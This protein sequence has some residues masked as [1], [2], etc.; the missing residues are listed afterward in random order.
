MGITD[1][2]DDTARAD[3]QSGTKRMLGITA[4][5]FVAVPADIPLVNEFPVH[6]L[7]LI[8]V[9]T[10]ATVLIWVFVGYPLLMLRFA[11]VHKGAKK[12]YAFQPFFSILVPT[13]NE[14]AVI[15]KRIQNLQALRYPK[16]KYEIL[17]IDSGSS[18]ATT[19]I[20]ERLCAEDGAP[21]TKLVC[22]DERMGKASAINCGSA[23]AAGDIILV[24]DANAFFDADVLAELGPHFERAEIGGV[25]G[26]YVVS[27]PENPLPRTE[28]FYW[29][30]ETLLRTGESALDSACLFQ[31]EINAWRKSIVDADT[32]M[33][34][35]DLDMSIAIRKKG[36]KVAFEP[37]AICYEPSPTSFSEQRTQKQRRCLGTIQNIFKH[38]RYLFVPTD[39][40]RLIIFPSHKGLLMATPFM[41]FGILVC[42]TLIWNPFVV[43]DHIFIMSALFLILLAVY[44]RFGPQLHRADVSTRPVKFSFLRVA[45]YVLFDEYLLLV[46]WIA[47]FSRRY[48]V[49]W[50]KIDSTRAGAE[51]AELNLD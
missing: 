33:I 40:Y 41:F 22:E 17:V 4:S 34:G 28:Q 18:D 31:G 47:F 30:L 51:P 49:L 36:Y 44:L 12:N 5:S 25:G 35:E 15:E 42:Y 13:F 20:V 38:W 50:E 21:R 48:S 45:G 6:T 32:A 23:H 8:A 37:N 9:Y 16:D 24:T 43:L 3:D 29:D 46:A 27:N 2:T 26:R 39:W 11:L 1:A 14:E 19:R 10:L 7:A